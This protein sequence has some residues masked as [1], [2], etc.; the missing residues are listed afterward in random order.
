MRLTRTLSTIALFIC[1]LWVGC[2]ETSMVQNED[3]G[4]NK[5]Q[6]SVQQMNLPQ[7]SVE[8]STLRAKKAMQLNQELFYK[9]STRGPLNVEKPLLIATGTGDPRKAF[10]SLLSKPNIKQN[11]PT[12]AVETSESGSAGSCWWVARSGIFPLD[13]YYDEQQNGWAKDIVMWSSMQTSLPVEYIEVETIHFKEFTP[14]GGSFD[15]GI[16]SDYVSAWSAYFKPP[17]PLYYW[18][19][20]VGH[21]YFRNDIPPAECLYL[22]LQWEVYTYVGWF[23]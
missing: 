23:Y 20:V 7:R 21:Q 11:A 4:L 2:Q 14:I 18:Y 9:K 8:D 10:S 5:A 13:L 17:D 6:S 3:Q 19:S 15:F 12:S 1:F 22:P 16:W